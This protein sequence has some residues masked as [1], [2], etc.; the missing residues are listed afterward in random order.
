MFSIAV[1]LPRRSGFLV[2]I[3]AGPSGKV[4]ALSVPDVSGHWKLTGA[5]KIIIPD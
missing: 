4:F 1:S 2:F 3:W 5:S